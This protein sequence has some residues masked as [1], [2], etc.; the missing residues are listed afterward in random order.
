MDDQSYGFTVEWHDAQADLI[1]EYSLTLFKPQKGPLEVAMY[2]P[3]AH[4]AFLKRMAVPDL[5]LEDFMVG[6]TV[7]IYARHLKVKSYADARTENAL[8]GVRN[9][10]AL[11]LQ[12]HA[13][14]QLGQVVSAIESVGLVIAKLRLVNHEGPVVAI[15]VAGDS[16]AE[17]WEAVQ[18][19]MP[20]D[21][22]RQVSSEEARPFFEDKASYPS[23]HAGDHCTLC[24][25]R[26]HAVKAGHAGEIISEIMNNGF[27]ISAAQMM[28]LQRAEAAEL[29]DV[30]KG[31]VPYFKEMVDGLYVAPCIMLELRRESNV[32][33]SFRNLCGPYDVD[34]AKHLRPDSLRAKFGI[35]NACNGVHST[36]LEDDAE[37][38]VRYVFEML[39]A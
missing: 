38:E 33:E 23:T 27:E 18:Q 34:M 24:I 35:S 7:T 20:P 28:H 11:I 4:R 36:D 3:K 39:A 30:Y 32:V 16:A 19:S 26:P 2:D 15:Q 1:R 10:F 22:C 14:V 12:P 25:I 9:E 31:V 13:F 17:K 8:H 29:L 5:R 21:F 6:S 37:L